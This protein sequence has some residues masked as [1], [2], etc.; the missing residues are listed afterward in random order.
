MEAY[1][2]PADRYDFTGQPAIGPVRLYRLLQIERPYRGPLSGG[3][4]FVEER[5]NDRLRTW[6]HRGAAPLRLPRPLTMRDRRPVEDLSIDE[7]QRVLA[8]KKRADIISGVFRVD[9][10]EA[11][12]PS[13]Q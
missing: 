6:P 1:H 13:G 10:N 2:S 8:E 5:S 3:V 11:A 4:C 7:L 9:I 12:P